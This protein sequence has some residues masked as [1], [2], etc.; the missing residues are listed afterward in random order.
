LDLQAKIS[1]LSSRKTAIGFVVALAFGVKLAYAPKNIEPGSALARWRSRIARAETAM[2]K[3]AALF[4]LALSMTINAALPAKAGGIR[5]KY[6]KAG[7]VTELSGLNTDLLCYPA[8]VRGKVVKRKF[9][10][11]NILVSG[12]ILEERDGSRE[13][14]NVE[15]PK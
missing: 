4:F 1:G 6:G 14:I 10:S 2:Q 7:E 12:L 13:F 15:I 3:V 11:D 5:Y 9:S 8:V